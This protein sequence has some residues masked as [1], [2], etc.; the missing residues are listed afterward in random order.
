M[1][2]TAANGFANK[3]ALIVIHPDGRLQVLWKP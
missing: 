3:T 1:A 2:T